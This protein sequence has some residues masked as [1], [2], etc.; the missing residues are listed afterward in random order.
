M[1]TVS[2]ASKTVTVKY[3]GAI[4]SMSITGGVTASPSG[5]STLD[6]PCGQQNLTI[7]VPAP[8]TSPSSVVTY[9]WSLPNGWSGTIHF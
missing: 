5:G 8:A 3:I 9:I 7:S 6:V 4:T 2:A 1:K